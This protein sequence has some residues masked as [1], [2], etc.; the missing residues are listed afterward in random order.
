MDVVGETMQQD[1]GWPIGG[2]DLAIG[3]IENTRADVLFGTG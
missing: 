2:T 3:D 1:G